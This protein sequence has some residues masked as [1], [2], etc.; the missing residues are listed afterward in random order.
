MLKQFYWALFWYWYRC[1]KQLIH[2]RIYAHFKHQALLETGTWMLLHMAHKSK[3]LSGRKTKC[4]TT[5][6]ETRNTHW[7]EMSAP[8]S[9]SVPAHLS[10]SLCWGPWKEESKSS[11]LIKR[12]SKIA[13]KELMKVQVVKRIERNVQERPRQGPEKFLFWE[14]CATRNN[15]GEW[16]E[17]GFWGARE[18]HTESTWPADTSS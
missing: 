8:A 10:C 18:L 15:D 2:S 1:Q 12:T 16:T 17:R 7:R 4:F 5:S 11:H 13:W 9:W 3:S 14:R 6:W